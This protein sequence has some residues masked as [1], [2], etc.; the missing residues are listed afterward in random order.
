MR[1]VV[2]ALLLLPAA[3]AFAGDYTELYR[4][5]IN[6]PGWEAQEP[7]GSSMS[8]PFGK[9]MT[10]MR[11]YTKGDATFRVTVATGPTAKVAVSSSKYNTSYDDG[12]ISVKVVSVGGKRAFLSYHKGEKSGEI[13]VVLSEAPNPAI[14][15]F[16]FSGV[17]PQTALRLA[18]RFPVL[19]IA[20]VV[21]SL[22]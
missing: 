21:S 22:R 8:G 16:S 20:R 6:L 19:K 18:N 1:K 3:V 17:D 7:E 15:N 4:Y 2:L 9:M 11:S 12:R 10:V 5:L 13:L 14:M